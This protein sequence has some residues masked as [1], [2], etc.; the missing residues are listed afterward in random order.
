MHF[1]FLVPHIP[2]E[3]RL[4]SEV[5]THIVENEIFFSVPLFDIHFSEG[6]LLFRG[7]G[8]EEMPNLLLQ[9]VFQ[10]V[11][12]IEVAYRDSIQKTRR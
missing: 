8:H 7:A 3:E 12:L 1:Y 6:R 4:L 10:T 11:G 9:E 5:I 2:S